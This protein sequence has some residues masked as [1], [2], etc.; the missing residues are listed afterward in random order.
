[1]EQFNLNWKTYSDNLKAMMRHLMQSQEYADV[2]LV[3]EDKLN[4]KAH[5]FV[6]NTCSSVFNNIISE[7]P[8]KDY[9]VI[10]LKGILAAEV[11]PILQ[12]MY[13]GQAT[14]D[15][16]R[17]NEFFK[18][19]KSLGI[20]EL[21][22]DVDSHSTLI[23]SDSSQS[24]EYVISNELEQNSNLQVKHMETE[25]QNNINEVEK[26]T[27][28]ECDKQYSEKYALNEHVRRRHEGKR[29]PCTK[30]DKEFVSSTYLEVHVKEFHEGLKY[31]CN[32]CSKVYK[33]RSKV[34]EHLRTF[35]EG[36]KAYSCD[37]CEKKYTHKHILDRHK[38]NTHDG[39]RYPCSQCNQ[40]YKTKEGL[41]VHTKSYHEGKKFHCDLCDYTA[42]Q[43]SSLYSHK[44]VNH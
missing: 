5:K 37:L 32:K 24:Y 31:P 15:K 12:F 38:E 2:T 27:S 30:C 4:L 13:L 42:N 25:I 8:N 3:C 43:K 39:V 22:K 26:S 16:N 10:Y 9:A 7:L 44:K 23:E 34:S 35:H 1:M 19:A 40:E 14:L 20:K 6:L 29:Y 11:R 18:V 21:S 28:N 41:V 17:M 36:I 33:D